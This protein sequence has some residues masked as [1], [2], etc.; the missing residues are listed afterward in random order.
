MQSSD[1]G[2]FRLII[3]DDPGDPYYNIALEEAIT[4]EIHY[5]YSPPALRLWR[6]RRSVVMGSGRRIH[7]DLFIQNIHD[8]E[9]PLIRRTSGG[10]TIVHHPDN[11]CYSLYFPFF[12]QELQ[13]RL[14]IKESIHLLCGII[15]SAL[16]KCG[17]DADISDRGDVRIGDRKVSGTAQQRTLKA[18]CHHGTILFESHIDEMERYLKIPKERKSSHRDFVTGL[19]SEGFNDRSKLFKA[20][21][22]ATSDSLKVKIE[23]G[24]LTEV[25]KSRAK[26]LVESRLKKEE[27]TYRL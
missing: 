7:E 14:K 4:R 22:D 24:Q 17:F 12:R 10:G 13:P 23:P 20:I 2:K 11:I 18:M 27:W 19:H 9:I 16:Q 6:C 1:P 25:E 21:K 26:K 15:I 8:D 3:Q 5:G